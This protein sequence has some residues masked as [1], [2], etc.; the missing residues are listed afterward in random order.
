MHYDKVGSKM[1]TAE[2]HS[3]RVASYHQA[4]KEFSL[5]FQVNGLLA[6]FWG[7]KEGDYGHFPF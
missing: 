2:V 5:T 1:L 6:D 4:G 3:S 7:V